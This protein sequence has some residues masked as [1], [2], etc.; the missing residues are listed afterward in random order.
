MYCFIVNETSGNGKGKK[1]W[2]KVEQML[3]EREI[4]Y[5]VYYTERPKH[6]IEIVKN[7]IQN[8]HIKA[9]IAV[10]G[11]GTLHDVANGLHGSQVPLG[12]I[13]AGSGND[14]IRGTKGDRQYEK[15]LDRILNRLGNGQTET[16]D[17]IRIGDEICLTVVGVG[18]DG[19]VAKV[20]NEASYKKWLNRMNLGHFSYVLSLIRVLF[21]YKPTQVKITVDGIEHQLNNVWLIAIANFPFYGGGMA[22]CPHANHTD[23]KLDLCILHDVSKIKLLTIFPLV[24]SGKHINQPNIT[25]L[26]GKNIE[27][28]SDQ[29]LV[30]HGDGEIISET[31]IKLNIEQ[32]ALQ[33]I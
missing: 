22:I 24:F 4:T 16:I 18:F 23:G 19:Q 14:F 3:I 6:A 12:C 28:V 21:Q 15:A 9:I 26:S 33:I 31:P 10:G 27:V 25:M 2:R 1:I 7:V 32:Q 29:P 11:D 13:P 5:S 8:E 17:M 20:T 30:V